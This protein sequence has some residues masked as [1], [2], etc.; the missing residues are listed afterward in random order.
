MCVLAR[1]IATHGLAEL[2][3]LILYWRYCIHALFALIGAGENMESADYNDNDM[4]AR[5]LLRMLAVNC[6]IISHALDELLQLTSER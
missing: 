6:T 1:N 3:Y 4:F 2:K 5:N